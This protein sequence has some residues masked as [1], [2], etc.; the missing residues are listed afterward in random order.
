M[1]D[2]STAIAAMVPR[3]R[4]V[5]AGEIESI[6]SFTGP[7]LRTDAALADGTGVVVL[8]FMGRGVPPGM[9]TGARVVPR[10]R[11]RS[12]GGVLLMRNPLYSF[13]AA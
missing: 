3:R 7:W 2:A 10:A 11:R 5:V 13:V 8:R 4:S 1:S 12:S 6:A 9:V